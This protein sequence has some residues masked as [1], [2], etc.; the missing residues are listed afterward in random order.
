MSII[1]T[2]LPQGE[3]LT[4]VTGTTPAEAYIEHGPLEH[5]S[6]ADRKA[7]WVPLDAVDYPPAGSTVAILNDG[8]L[9][10][11]PSLSQRM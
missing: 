10:L 2:I 4:S 1:I 5:M 7:L 6:Y 3:H 11:H 8:R 9:T